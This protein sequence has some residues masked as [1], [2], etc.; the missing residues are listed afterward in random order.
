[1]C[2]EQ[3]RIDQHLRTIVLGLCF[4]APF[5]PP[6]SSAQ[7]LPEQLIQT[8]TLREMI[9]GSPSQGRDGFLLAYI[10]PGSPY[11]F[12]NLGL[13]HQVWEVCAPN[14]TPQ[15]ETG[16]FLSAGDGFGDMVALTPGGS[17]FLLGDTDPTGR[18]ELC[19]P[20][21]TDDT[22]WF[23]YGNSLN[24]SPLLAGRFLGNE[25]TLQVPTCD[26]ISTPVEGLLFL[27]RRSAN[28]QLQDISCSTR[29]PA[30]PLRIGT[31]LNCSFTGTWLAPDGT[32]L[33]PELRQCERYLV[34]SNTTFGPVVPLGQQCG[35]P[36]PA[37]GPPNL[38]PNPG[39]NPTPPPTPPPPTIQCS[40]QHG[41]GDEVPKTAI[42]ELAQPSGTFQFDY[43]TLTVPD[44]IIVRYEGNVLFDT[45]CVGASGSQSLTYSGTSTQVEVQVIPVC[46]G[47]PDTEWYW[48]VHCPQ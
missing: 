32:N 30:Y 10:I 12:N 8:F 28:R 25:D 22:W 44:Q 33:V 21:D 43:D 40:V 27:E 35:V 13:Y 45:G 14:P 47:D 3:R 38:P 18:T 31:L 16:T 9:Q 1:M 26:F 37:A 15:G 6:P 7:P 11:P 19:N 48:T 29:D 42:V 23:A 5:A 34:C 4:F 24:I 39:G 46:A 2:H 20:L 41:G 36:T 17:P